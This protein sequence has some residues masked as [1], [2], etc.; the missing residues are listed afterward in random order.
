M[1]ADHGGDSGNIYIAR[2]WLGAGATP[3]LGGRGK[4]GS[5][6]LLCLLTS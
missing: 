4:Q 1:R 2:C 5:M 3:K 6:I